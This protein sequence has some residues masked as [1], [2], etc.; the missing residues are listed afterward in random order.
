MLKDI[1]ELKVEDLAVAIGPRT[2]EHAHEEEFWDVFLINLGE[3]S[4]RGV[5]VTSKA[6]GH[7]EGERREST[8]FRQFFEEIGALH[9]VHLEPIHRDLFRITNEF[10]VS[11]SLDGH[12]Y[13]R[14]YIF[15]EGS[16]DESFLIGIPFTDRYGVIIR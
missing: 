2:L 9:T 15:V 7:I 14:K 11:F 13:D 16:L 5:F 10:W 4:L 6:Y 3:K 1:A 8:V 12:L